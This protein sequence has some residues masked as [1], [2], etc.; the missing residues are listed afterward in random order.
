MELTMSK[1]KPG[2]LPTNIE[3]YGMHNAIWTDSDL[4]KFALMAFVA[5]F[6]MGVIL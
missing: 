3:Q 5:G 6:I 2:D 1:W 4:A